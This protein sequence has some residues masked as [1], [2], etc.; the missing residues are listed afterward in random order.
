MSGRAISQQGLATTWAISQQGLATTC[1]DLL[2]EVGSEVVRGFW[3]GAGACMS[4]E[5]EVVL[6][7]AMQRHDTVRGNTLSGQRGSR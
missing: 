1:K 4:D 7:D 3:S 5:G 6:S 2:Y